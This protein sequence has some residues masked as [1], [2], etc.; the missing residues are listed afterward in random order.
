MTNTLKRILILPVFNEEKHVGSLLNALEDRIDVFIVINDGSLD[1]SEEKIFKWAHNRDNFYYLK[2]RLNS[3]MASALKKG[4]LQVIKLLEGNTVKGDDIII[5][6]DADG[7]HNPDYIDGMVRHMRF[8]KLDVL[9]AK[10]DLFNYPFRRRFGNIA[11]TSYFNIL[12]NYKYNDVESG[13][14]LLKVNIIPKVIKYY[15]GCRYSNAQ[16]IAMITALLNYKIDNNYVIKT[17][18]H[19]KGG[20]GFID[21]IINITMSTAVF[22]KIKFKR[23]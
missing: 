4:F 20:P 10:R 9:L 11:M 22:L 23:D 19:R 5:T 6:M 13:F 1:S 3:G 21:A 2:S 14:R 15:T 17:S 16:E 12:S 8:N 7:Q 18:Y